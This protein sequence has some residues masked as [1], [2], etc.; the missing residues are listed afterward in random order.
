MD[1]V[2]GSDTTR[3]TQSITNY[4]DNGAGLVRVTKATHGL[5]TGAIIDITGSGVA[6]YNGAWK[7]TVIDSSNFDLD[8]STYSSNPATKGQFVPRGGSSWTDAWLT[9]TSG[10]TAARVAAG[11]TIRIAKTDDPVSIGNATWTKNS[12][13]VTLATAQ[14]VTIDNCETAWTAANSATVTRNNTVDQFKEGSY[15]ANIVTPASTLTNTK[16]AYRTLPATLN[17]STYNAITFWIYSDSHTVAANNLVIKLCSDTTGDTAVDTFTFPASIAVQQRW[18]PV[19]ITRDGGGNLGSNIQSISYYTGSSNP[20]NTRT[21]RFDNFS[22]CSSTGLN[23]NMLIGRSSN[24]YSTTEPWYTMNGIDGTTITLGGETNSSPRAYYGW[25]TTGSSPSTVTTY[26]LKPLISAT[27]RTEQSGGGLWTLNTSGT[28][29]SP[30]V[31]SGGWNKTNTTQDGC[32]WLDNRT[33]GGGVLWYHS[34]LRD[35]NSFYRLGLSRFAYFWNPS[36]TASPLASMGVFESLLVAVNQLTGY[37][38]NSFT[39]TYG[40]TS[41]CLNG[42]QIQYSNNMHDVLNVMSLQN[43]MRLSYGS[44]KNATSANTNGQALTLGSNEIQASDITVYRASTI[45]LTINGNRSYVNK[46]TIT[47]CG[48]FALLTNSS[49]NSFINGFTTSGNASGAIQFNGGGLLDISNPSISESTINTWSSGAV[50]GTVYFTNYGGSAT[51]NRAYGV[52]WNALSQT[53]TRKS[54]TGIAWQTNVTNSQMGIN[55]PV[56]MS[57]A[58]IACSGNKQVTVK[59]WVKLSHA[60]DIGAKLFVAKGQLPG[61]TSDAV[62]TKSADTNWEELTVTF[63]PT[64]AGVVEV[65][66]LSYWLANTADES[67]FIDDMTILEAP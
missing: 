45:G 59:A 64:I 14:T 58:K 47:D 25:Y 35:Y 52:Y 22:A 53:T 31:W 41:C 6:A 8:T 29:T 43:G 2:S 36:I 57:V 32:T 63:T 19:T 54:S 11:D 9:P 37:F 38:N 12:T 20:G 49:G 7:V 1:L 34:S 50:N 21:Y 39:E 51:D 46:L 28:L 42:Y 24:S 18:I 17:L 56:K 66:L 62:A 26:Y 67:T 33:T 44:I 3:A 27:T 40:Y 23:L 13:T 5:V 10:A 61:L 30:V 16:Y 60:T 65:E 48:T 55:F 4:S 15:S